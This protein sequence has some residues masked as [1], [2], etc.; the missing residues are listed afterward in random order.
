MEIFLVMIALFVLAI[1]IGGS[2]CGVIALIIS[3]KRENEIKRLAGT[4][5]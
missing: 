3:K 1:L 5:E 2:I 4:I